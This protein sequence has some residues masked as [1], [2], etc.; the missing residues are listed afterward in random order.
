MAA[1]NEIAAQLAS[2]GSRVRLVGFADIGAASELETY[3]VEDW[4]AGLHPGRGWD[5]ADALDDG[6]TQ[7]EIDAFMQATVRPFALSGAQDEKPVTVENTSAAHRGAKQSSVT[8]RH[9]PER[10][11]TGRRCSSMKPIF[12]KR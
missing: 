6:W 11:T 10:E 8:C 7:A 9:R 1:A 2:L 5:C 12:R 4:R 3:R